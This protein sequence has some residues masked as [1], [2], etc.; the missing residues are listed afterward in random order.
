MSNQNQITFIV[1]SSQHMCLDEWNSWERAPYSAETINID[2]TITYLQTY[3]D[4]NVQY[5]HTYTQY[6]QCTVRHTYSYQYTLYTVCTH[7]TLC[8]HLYT[9]SNMQRCS[10]LYI[11][12]IRKCHGCALDSIQWQQIDCCICAVCTCCPVWTV[13][14]KCSAWH[15]VKWECAVGCISSECKCS[16]VNFEGWV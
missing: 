11:S 10:R 1:T 15:I 6:T 3:T 5:T 7:S 2:S 13:E 9:H 8:T 14:L 16:S 12:W 4:D